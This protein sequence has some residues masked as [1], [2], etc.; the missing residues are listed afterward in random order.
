M[1][2]KE[3]IREELEERSHGK[4]CCRKAY[5][6]GLLYAAQRADDGKTYCVVLYEKKDADEAAALIDAHFSSGEGCEITPTSRGGHKA[7]RLRLCSRSI[8]TALSLIDTARAEDIPTAVGFRCPECAQGFLAGL[9]LASASLSVPKGGYSLEFSTVGQ[10]RADALCALLEECV[11]KPACIKR[12][13]RIGVYYKSNV[14]IS[15]FLYFIG[16]PRQSFEFANYSIE[17]EIRN[18]ENRITNCLTGNISRAV[19][20]N[21]R[22]I[23]AIKRLKS[24]GEFDKLPKKL[25]YTAELRLENDVASLSE[26][27]LMHNPPISKSGLNARL[28]KIMKLAYPDGTDSQ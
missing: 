28:A 4:N 6:C 8:G 13:E 2:L 22:V 20:S 14:K 10:R 27:A 17:R 3:K 23:A 21:A 15:D 9:F 1:S 25:A 19:D 26:L 12:A 5:L 11:G 16:A 24:S 7:Y 18:S